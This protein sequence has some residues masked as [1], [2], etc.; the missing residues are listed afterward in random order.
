MRFIAVRKWLPDGSVQASSG[1]E[2]RANSIDGLF[3]NRIKAVPQTDFQLP[4]DF[5]QWLAKL[6]EVHVVRFKSNNWQFWT[7]DELQEST[8]V[9]KVKTTQA[10]MMTAFVAMYRAQ[11]FTAAKGAAGKPFPYEQLE[12]CLTL[13]TDNEEFLIADPAGDFSVWKFCPDY[14]KCGEVKP[15]A[16]TLTQFLESATVEDSVDEDDDY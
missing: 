11:G 16:T 15:L 7:L 6:P 2:L 13:A 14:A 9:D 8:R 3:A 10:H 1:F 5:L 12:R 4:G